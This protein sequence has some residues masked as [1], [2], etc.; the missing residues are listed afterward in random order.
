[1]QVSIEST[2]NIERRMTIGVPA[3]EVEKEV[4]ARLQRTARSVKLNGFRP[5]K[6]PMHVV[7]KRFGASVKQEVVGELMRNAYIEALEKESI[8]PAGYPRFEPKEIE[9]G[10]DL[11]FVAIFEVYPKIEICD[12]A[13]ISVEKEVAEIKDKDVQNMLEVLRRQH[14][15]FKP[16][17]RKSKK[18]DVL[19]LDYA[20]TIDG[21]AF[22]GG[23][24]KGAKLTLGSGQ[25]IPGFEDALVGAKAGDE[26]QIDV[27]FPDDYHAEKLAGKAAKFDV[28][29]HGVDEVVL[30][31]LDKEF[32]QKY[33]VE[34]ETEEEFA[35]EI[36]KNMERELKQ[37]TS[38]KVK[39]L[40]VDQLIEK[41]AFDV[42]ESLIASEIGRL[43]EEAFKQ[44]GGMG[45]KMKSSD[46]PSEIFRDQADRRV[47]T[48]LLFNELI[49]SNDLK[50]DAEKVKQRIEEV[51]S[52]YEQ[53]E[54][55]VAWYESNAAQKSQV[56]AVVLEDMVIDTILASAKVKEKK[57]SYEDA[58]KPPAKKET[59]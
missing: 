44:F 10:K 35:V 15:T 13:S 21:E 54:E 29:V 59:K 11:E 52:T 17:K 2:S 25:M 18:K 55:V 20:G 49:A 51:A 34:A 56:E 1:M 16:V 4:D 41:T 28:T 46:L 48:G 26:L 14:A 58:V 57:V 43:K 8:N 6:V 40:V 38:N 39:Q 31:E 3:P 9:D 7:R 12:L 50:V 47:R 36:R 5:G 53:P 33:G 45:G 42:P 37:A 22:D 19:T 27:T 24:T 32:F 30:P 23:S